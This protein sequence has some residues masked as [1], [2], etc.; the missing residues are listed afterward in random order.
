M[1]NII[2]SVY[3]KVLREGVWRLDGFRESCEDHVLQLNCSLRERIH[4]VEMVVTQE[5]WVIL[6]DN[7][8]YIHCSCVKAPHRLGSLLTR[9]QIVF[10]KSKTLTEQLFDFFI[11]LE[12]SLR[13]LRRIFII[14]LTIWTLNLLVF[15]KVRH[16]KL[17]TDELK[18]CECKGWVYVWTQ[19]FKQVRHLEED[20]FLNLLVQ[21]I[22]ICHCTQYVHEKSIVGLLVELTL[23]STVISME[24]LFYELENF[25]HELQLV[26][27]FKVLQENEEKHGQAIDKSVIKRVVIES[28]LTIA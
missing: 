2:H 12:L 11:L 3:F 4:E 21:H 23:L 10:D 25:A 18:P 20:L 7:K 24:L 22:L 27:L 17:M 28:F 13:N 15:D 8:N 6:E 1:T 14:F 5:L 9:Y 16:E 26:K 19:L